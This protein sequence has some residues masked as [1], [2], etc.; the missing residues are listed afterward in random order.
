MRINRYILLPVL[1]WAIPLAL[2]FALPYLGI[3]HSA[4]GWLILIVLLCPLI[5]LLVVRRQGN[6][7][8]QHGRKGGE[9]R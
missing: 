5:H 8:H 7:H 4:S 6:A 1:C 9:A 2:I 3:T